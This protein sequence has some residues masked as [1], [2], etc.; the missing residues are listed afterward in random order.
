M[1]QVAR[2]SFIPF[3]GSS[4]PLEIDEKYTSQESKDKTVTILGCSR[5][6]EPLKEP[7]AE[8]YNI[9]KE[10]VN[11]GY[12]VL[13]GCGNKGIMGA[14]YKGALSAEKNQE[15]PE[16][17]L[18]VLV[19]PS[20]G[21]EDIKH[22][23]VIAKPASS[24]SD[25]IENGFL[26]ASNNFLIFPGGAGSMQEASTLIAKN[27]CC[28]GNS[29]HLNV[30]LVG[31]DYYRGLEQQYDDMYKAGALRTEPK[32]LFKIIEAED[33]LKNFPDLKHSTG[34]KIY[35]SA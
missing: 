25:R 5:D 35:T 3:S 24:E 7:M 13:T 14:A 6:A 32:K 8:A 4:N 27:K 29:Q 21:N 22:C 34:S 23:K 26:K 30:L 1:M 17:N 10:L 9:A 33:V 18:A 2:I 12:N 19:N 20:W 16:K 31:K 11:R 28:H 15:N